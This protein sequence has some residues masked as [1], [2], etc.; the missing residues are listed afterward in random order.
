[1]VIIAPSWWQASQHQW[2]DNTIGAQ[3]FIYDKDHVYSN[4]I[5]G[6]SLS[7]RLVKDSLKDTYV[8]AFAGLS[9]FD[10]LKILIKEAQLPKTIF[11]EMNFILRPENEDFINSLFSPVMFYPRSFIL[12]LREKKQPVAVVGR[13]GPELVKD[14]VIKNL[15]LQ[16]STDKKAN[17]SETQKPHLD[18]SILLKLQMDDYAKTPEQ[19]IVDKS[20]TQ[21]KEYVEILKKRGVYIVFFEMPVNSKLENLPKAAV[22][23]NT[24]YKYFSPNEYQYTNI[25]KELD[26][27][28][29]DGIHLGGAEA[30]KYTRYFNDR[31][32]EFFQ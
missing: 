27:K 6:S 15:K 32:S 9:A 30:L 25:P 1:M 8:L 4:V 12:A 2:Q 13:V 26:F 21:L 28:T 17:T 11:I 7:T 10:G 31:N 20:F 16:S 3:E 5:V 14:M 29:T 23:R 18:F 22:I 19:E 24:F